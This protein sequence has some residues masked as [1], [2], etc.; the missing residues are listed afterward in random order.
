MISNVFEK[1]L[2]CNMSKM[3]SENLAKPLNLSSVSRK[4]YIR[5]FF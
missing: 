1:S 3:L 4:G 2:N 5:I